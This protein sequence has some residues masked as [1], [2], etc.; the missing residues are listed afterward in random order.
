[1]PRVVWVWEGDCPDIRRFT[2]ETVG[3][4]KRAMLRLETL[5][6]PGEDLDE[7]LIGTFEQHLDIV[8]LLRVEYLPS[9]RD[10]REL[11]V[12]RTKVRAG[13]C[14]RLRNGKGEWGDRWIPEDLEEPSQAPYRNS[15]LFVPRG[16]TPG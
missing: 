12:E 16:N 11:M 6:W 5:C 10:A 13:R 8:G 9:R 3:W 2:G 1:M 4:V 7:D 15:K 14:A